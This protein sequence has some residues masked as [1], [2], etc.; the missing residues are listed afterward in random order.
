M[1]LEQGILKEVSRAEN[2][3]G[4]NNP[5]NVQCLG[6]KDTDCFTH[7]KLIEI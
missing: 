5:K 4:K 1:T 3:P 6:N 2:K 7:F